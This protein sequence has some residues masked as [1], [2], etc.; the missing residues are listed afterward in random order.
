MDDNSEDYS[1]DYS[2]IVHGPFDNISN[3]GSSAQEVYPVNSN[4]PSANPG[5]TEKTG[6]STEISRELDKELERISQEEADKDK[7]NIAEAKNHVKLIADNTGRSKKEVWSTIYGT[8]RNEGKVTNPN[9]VRYDITREEW[10]SKTLS[11]SSP[12]LHTSYVQGC[13][14]CEYNAGYDIPVSCTHTEYN[15]NCSY[16][17][18]TEFG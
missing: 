14:H 12:C 2:G 10:A 17:I 5:L 4:P 18:S 1:D 7:E 13:T 6:P 16:C 8:T 15:E 11:D 9:T 3:D